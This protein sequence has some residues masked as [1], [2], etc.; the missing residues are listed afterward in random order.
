MEKIDNKE[1]AFYIGYLGTA[2][3]AVAT[4]IRRTV[5]IIGTVVMALCVTLVIKQKTFSSN[6]FNYGELTTV[7]GYLSTSP[8]PHLRLPI[9]KD[10]TGA[11]QYQKILLVGFGKHG[12]QDWITRLKQIHGALPPGKVAVAGN[13]IYGE[14]KT[15]MQVDDIQCVKVID[16]VPAAPEPGLIVL[17]NIDVSGEIVDPKCYFGVMKPGESKVHRS[18]AA[19]CIA[20]GI[21]PVFHGDDGEFY[22]LTMDEQPAVMFESIAPVIGQKISLTAEENRSDDW[23]VLKVNRANLS[24][25]TARLK[26]RQM[27]DEFQED[28]TLCSPQVTLT[29][30]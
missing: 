4:V 7:E 24:R 13:L 20:G 27:L 29:N 30:R 2:P 12:A 26:I 11:E 1:R 9:G 28:M 5:M 8:V 10:S 17:R 18:C 3:E 16:T 6:T 21:P 22:L 14:G 25:V 15:W 23:K 19:R